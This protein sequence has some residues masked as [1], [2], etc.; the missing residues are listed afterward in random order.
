MVKILRYN[1]QT[2]VTPKAPNTYSQ[3][4]FNPSDFSRASD[5]I[6]QVGKQV[7]STGLDLFS[8][9]E[10]NKSK[11]A[12][13]LSNQDMKMLETLEKQK[14]TMDVFQLKMD[15]A[16]TL[17][18]KMDFALNGTAEEPGLTTFANDYMHN[19]DYKNNERNFAD[20]AE[21]MKQSIAA[22]IEDDVVRKDFEMKFDNKAAALKLNVMNGSF[23]TGLAQRTSAY[24]AEHKQLLYEMEYGNHLEQKNAKDRLLGLNGVVGIHEEAFDGG[25]INTTPELAIQYSQ[26]EVEFIKAKLMIADDPQA[27]MDLAKGKTHDY[28]F[29][30]LTVIQR[31]DLDIKAQKQIDILESQAAAATKKMIAANQKTVSDISASLDDGILPENGLA[32]LGIARSIAEDLGDIDTIKEIDNHFAMWSTYQAAQQSNPLDLQAQINE[33]QIIIN[34][35][36]TTDLPMAAPGQ[37]SAAGVKEINLLKMKAL[38]NTKTKMDAALAKDSLQWANQV[39]KITLEP[40][41]LNADAES[42]KKWVTNRQGDGN[43][44]AAV[45]GTKRDFLTKDEQ[46]MI[47]N[48]WQSDDTTMDQKIGLIARLSEFGIDADNVFEEILSKGDGKKES[49]YFAH[50]AGLM[51]ANPK[52]LI[53]GELAVSFFNGFAKK[54]DFSNPQ[55]QLLLGEDSNYTKT[56]FQ[57]LFNNAISGSFINADPEMNKTIFDMANIIYLDRAAKTSKSIDSTLYENII[58]ELIG[59]TTVGGVSYGG[60]VEYNNQS[61]HAPAWIKS[62]DFEIVINNL[63]DGEF[64]LV[65]NGQIP[66]WYNGSETGEFKL[67]GDVFN[68]DYDPSWLEDKTRSKGAMISDASNYNQPYLWVVGDGKYIISFNTPFNNEDPQYLATQNNDNGYFVLDLNKIKDLYLSGELKSQKFP[69]YN[70]K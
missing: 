11:K 62:D 61:T 36:N 56:Q 64:E 60:I 46:Q 26:G 35:S 3:T 23:K 22:T 41:N 4:R 66:I 12:E 43:Q 40:M 65:S 5:A 20:V 16:N 52:S 44:T 59:G 19:Q 48:Y 34:K 30:N 24:K 53:T 32:E 31:S 45:Y 33:L 54:D 15:R 38:Q 69:D 50:I 6:G 57:D 10:L 28:P 39:G 2:G 70:I 9:Q 8:Q 58:N 29:K 55:T 42:W 68:R 27:Y 13:Q 47:M 67:R 17:H 37:K 1:K 7:T 25:I 49:H 63:S 51:N 18:E 21:G 14:T